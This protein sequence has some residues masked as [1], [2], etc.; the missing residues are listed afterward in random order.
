MGQHQITS[1][2]NINSEEILKLEEDWD[3]GQF[4]DADTNLINRHNTHSE[5][6]RIRKEYTEHLLDLSEN[7]YYSEENPINQLQYSSTD[8]DYYWTPSRR[9]QTQPCDPAG[10]YPPP[11]DPAD[12]QCWHPCGRGKHTLLYGHRLF[13]E[14]IQSAESRKARKR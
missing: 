13:G 14:K 4:T 6:D 8:P 12:I 11:L 5:S 3:N 1:R 7:Q 2:Q 10:Y 9:S